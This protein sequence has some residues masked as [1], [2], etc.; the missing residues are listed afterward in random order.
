MKNPPF[1]SPRAKV[2]GLF[3]LGRLL[4]KIRL[5]LRGEL[6][7]EYKPNLGA[8]HGLDG[9]CC[10]FLGV[11]YDDLV[12]RL[13]Q[14]GSDEELVEWCFTRGLRPNP[15]QISVW[16]GF[17]EK[18]GWRDRAASFITKVKK[19]DGVEHHDDLQTSF[20]CIDYREG[21]A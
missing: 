17:A 18:F 4:D 9:H 10:G 5:N 7:D 21:R 20:D 12:E 11:E 6:P 16:N 1:R 8:K 14:G 2:G 15:V 13:K 3:H 19:E